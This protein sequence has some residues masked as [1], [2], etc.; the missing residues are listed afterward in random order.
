[1]LDGTLLDVLTIL[2]ADFLISVYIAYIDFPPLA[3]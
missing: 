1:M 2:K 3:R